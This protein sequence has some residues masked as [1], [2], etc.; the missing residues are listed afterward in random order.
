[1]SHE[2][3]FIVK[4]NLYEYESIGASYVLKRLLD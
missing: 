1:M 3:A 4:S 2:R